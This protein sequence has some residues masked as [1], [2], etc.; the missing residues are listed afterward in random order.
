[1][2]FLKGMLL[3]VIVGASAGAVLVA[4]NKKLSGKV[5]EKTDI[6]KKKLSNTLS[7]IKQK[8]DECPK[9]DCECN[10]EGNSEQ[11]GKLEQT[12]N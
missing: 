7:K 9:C 8:L 10:K 1:M 4:T 5:K 11:N 2:N 12:Q 6:A 3:G